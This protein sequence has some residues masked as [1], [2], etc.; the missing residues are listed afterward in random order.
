MDI[1]ADSAKVVGRSNP[2]RILRE[3]MMYCITRSYCEK[4]EVKRD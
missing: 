2:K 4:G 3:V 1:S